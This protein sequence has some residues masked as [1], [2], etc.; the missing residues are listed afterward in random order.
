VPLGRETG[1]ET[2]EP[3]DVRKEGFPMK[4]TIGLLA[5]AFILASLATLF[6]PESAFAQSC[7]TCECANFEEI[8]WRNDIG[9][10]GIYL[11][12]QTGNFSG[13]EDI[14]T[15]ITCTELVGEGELLWTSSYDNSSTVC[16]GDTIPEQVDD[17][18]T[19]LGDSFFY[20]YRSCNPD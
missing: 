2:Q 6:A 8:P 18:L 19:G 11:M 17:D 14:L 16:S 4:R 13:V 7:H 1:H 15:L 12:Q 10:G 20:Q 9:E 5:A 3:S